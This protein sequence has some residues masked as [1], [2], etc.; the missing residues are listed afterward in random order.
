LA[1]IFQ[2][3]DEELRQDRASQLWKKYGKYLIV[4]ALTIVLGVAGYRFWKKNEYEGRE[5]ASALYEMATSRAD[6]G[7]LDDAIE[8]LSDPIMRNNIGYSVLSK[9]QQANFAKARGD[10]DAV[11]TTFKAI[12]EDEDNPLFIRDFSRFNYLSNQYQKTSRLEV[13]SQL[14]DLIDSGGPWSYLAREMKGLIALD[15]GDRSKASSIFQNLVDDANTPKAM[16]N[17]VAELLKTFP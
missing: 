8:I 9:I 2:E 3:I 15:A 4:V 16:R 10:Y 13:P 12:A 7:K 5:R 1:D 6:S 17:R 14:D 11:L